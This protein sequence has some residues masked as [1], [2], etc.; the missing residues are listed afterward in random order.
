MSES[1]ELLMW[2]GNS[3]GQLGIGNT[4]RKTTPQRVMALAG[5]RVVDIVLCDSTSLALVR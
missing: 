2:G 4:A 1:G 3:Q 5:K